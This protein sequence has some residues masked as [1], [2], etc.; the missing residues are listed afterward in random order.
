MDKVITRLD[1]LNAIWEEYAKDR[2]F[3]GEAFIDHRGM[4]T[5]VEEPNEEHSGYVFL[6]YATEEEIAFEQALGV[7]EAGF[8]EPHYNKVV[9]F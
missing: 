9:E 3:S 6:R 5:E 4:W 1:V 8:S 2:G 7:V